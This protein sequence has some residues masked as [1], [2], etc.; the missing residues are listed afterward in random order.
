MKHKKTFG[1]AILALVCV[2]VFLFIR[3]RHSD[4]ANRTLKNV[5]IDYDLIFLGGSIWYN[6]KIPVVVEN[7]AATNN[8]FKKIFYS[9][10]TTTVRELLNTVVPDSFVWRTEGH[11]IHIIS[12]SLDARPDYQL[13]APIEIFSATGDYNELIRT[14]LGRVN[15]R[16]FRE[17]IAYSPFPYEA[18]GREKHLREFHVTARNVT[19]RQLLDKI[20]LKGDTGY[21]VSRSFQKDGTY[22]LWVVEENTGKQSKIKDPSNL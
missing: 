12:K 8:E 16:N 14:A 15:R 20:V 10:K 5:K 4:I 3:E 22:I 19:L 18:L 21:S 7:D 1:F 2:F 9:T 6:Y 17:Q 13:N 11:V